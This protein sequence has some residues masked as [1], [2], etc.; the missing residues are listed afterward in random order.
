MGSAGVRVNDQLH[1]AVPPPLHCSPLLLYGLFSAMADINESLISALP[2]EDE[3]GIVYLIETPQQF[4]SGSYASCQ[5]A[6]RLFISHLS[7]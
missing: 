4:W 2:M 7:E 5:M 1:T 6:T 3:L